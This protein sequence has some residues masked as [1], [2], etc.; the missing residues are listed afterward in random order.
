MKVRVSKNQFNLLLEAKK[1]FFKR[2]S[3]PY[4]YDDL[5]D[6]VGYE[7]MWEHYNKHYKGYTT[8][9]N[10]ALSKR[11]RAPKKIE[12]LI[13]NIKNYDKFTRDNAGGY[14]NHSLFWTYLSPKETKPSKKLLEKINSQFGSMSNF[15]RQFDEEAQKVFGSGWCWL[16]KKNNTLKIISTPNQDNPL[17]DDKGFPLLGL[18]VWEHAYY[19][20]YMAD[21]KKYIRNF[22]KVVNW[23]TVSETYEDL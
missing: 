8:K 22:W 1:A 12:T 3:L 10:E 9:L 21:R 4:K 6:F 20:N 2:V 23:D 5:K 18:D 16:I 7:T 17:M 19:L 14:Y 13:K 15:K 11:K